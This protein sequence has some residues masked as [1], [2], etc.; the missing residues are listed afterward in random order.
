LKVSE[1]R[2]GTV[3]KIR[4]DKPTHISAAGGYIDIHLGKGHYKKG[5]KVRPME[6][7]TY[8]KKDKGGRRWVYFRGQKRCI[9]PNSWQHIVPLDEDIL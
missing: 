2:K 7:I 5:S 9:F 6:P 3:Y 4:S 8:I 1:L